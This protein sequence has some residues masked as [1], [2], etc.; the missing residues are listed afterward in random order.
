M[1]TMTTN[2]NRQRWPAYLSL[3]TLVLALAAVPASAQILNGDFEMG[4]TDWNFNGPAS[5]F[6]DY[7]PAGGNPDGCAIIA[8][9]LSGSGGTGCLIQTFNCGEQGSDTHCAIAFDFWLAPDN[10][11]AP[12]TGRIFA[13]VDGSEVFAHVGET[14]GWL[15]ASFI[16][17]CGVHVIELCLEVDDGDHGWRAIFDNVEASCEDTVPTDGSTWSSLKG[18]FR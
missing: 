3:A 13:L 15:Q 8:S 14:G 16:V 4:G 7:P 6:N 2:R 17:P 5:W 18:L 12:D 10:N 9:P 11:T 1:Q